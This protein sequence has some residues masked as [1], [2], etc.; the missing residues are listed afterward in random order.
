MTAE[1]TAKR[2]NKFLSRLPNVGKRIVYFLPLILPLIVVVTYF[3]FYQKFLLCTPNH[4]CSPFTSAEILAG[5]SNSDQTRV[6]A[7]V[8]R[9]S[10]TL[11]NG[12]HFLACLC[13]IVTAGIVIYKALAE[14]EQDLR[15]TI[16][17]LTVAAALDVGFGISLLT[18]KDVL[19]PA[20]QLHRATIGQVLPSI[21]NYNRIAEALGLASALSLA[22]AACAILWQRN[23][24]QQPDNETVKKR[25]K[26]LKAVLYVGAATLVLSVLRLAA[27]HAWAVSY[28]PPESDLGKGVATLATGIIG[29][30]GT[31]YTLLIAGVYLPAA[32]ILRSQ[33]KE[34]ANDKSSMDGWLALTPRILALIAPFLAGPIGKLLVDATNSFGGGS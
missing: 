27:T 22:V 28:L 1:P 10:W 34:D 3:L 7:Y 19:A 8:A 23:V 4:P 2:L 11:V 6:A 33:Y 25:M 30:L 13:A 12:I 20:Q 21:S 16:V 32:L 26:L 15:R 18:L 29:S 14:Y 31:S 17:L 5:V 24:N 9:T